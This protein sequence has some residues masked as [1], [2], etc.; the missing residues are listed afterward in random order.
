[1]NDLIELLQQGID[2]KE[3]LIVKN[4]GIREKN[5]LKINELNKANENA[6]QLI[7]TYEKDVDAFNAVIDFINTL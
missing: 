5:T 1:M 3:R 4:T 7:Q 6:N 2:E